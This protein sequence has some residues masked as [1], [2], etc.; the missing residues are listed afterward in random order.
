MNLKV[1]SLVVAT[2]LCATLLCGKTIA[3]EQATSTQQTVKDDSAT[4]ADV[5]EHLD[6]AN[7]LRSQ[8]ELDESFSKLLSALSLVDRAVAEE[9]Y[10]RAGTRRL[11]YREMERIAIGYRSVGNFDRAELLF[12]LIL[13]RLLK[14]NKA[15]SLEGL[16]AWDNLASVHRLQGNMDL[17]GE[18]YARV[19]SRAIQHRIDQTKLNS[20]HLS[21][22]RSAAY[23]LMRVAE[24]A[25]LAHNSEAHQW[26]A[27]SVAYLSMETSSRGMSALR[28]A[29]STQ[30]KVWKNLGAY[31]DLLNALSGELAILDDPTVNPKPVTLRRCRGLDRRNEI[32]ANIAVLQAKLGRQ[33]ESERELR[34]LL[35]IA[36][37]SGAMASEG[38]IR[39]RND[40]L[41]LLA[42]EGRLA[43][44]DSLLQQQL[45]DSQK[46]MAQSAGLSEDLVREAFSCMPGMADVAW[47]LGVQ[48]A[49]GQTLAAREA[50]SLKGAAGDIVMD[51][52]RAHFRARTQ[53]EL[54]KRV[55]QLAQIATARSQAGGV[56][57]QLPHSP[58]A[59]QLFLEYEVNTGL[60][61]IAYVQAG[62]SPDAQDRAL[63]ESEQKDFDR[64]W[65]AF[66]AQRKKFDDDFKSG[67]WKTKPFDPTA[68]RSPEEAELDRAFA[69]TLHPGATE[70]DQV[71]KILGKRVLVVFR[72]FRNLATD[73]DE[74]ATAVIDR[75]SVNVMGLGKWR[76][77]RTKLTEFRRA[78]VEM[79]APRTEQTAGEL[80]D[81]LW[82]PVKSLLPDGAE[83]LIIPDSDLNLLPFAALHDTRSNKYL[84]ETNW[85][86]MVASGRDLLRAPMTEAFSRPAVV[87]SP[88]FMVA[89][90]EDESQQLTRKFTPQP[91]FATEGKLV[92]AALGPHAPI[93]L[94]GA[95][96]TESAVKALASPLYL[97]FSTHAY[98]DIG[99]TELDSMFETPRPEL[100]GLDALASSG[101]ALTGA[102]V[103]GASL[104]RFNDGLLTSLEVSALDLAGTRLVVLSACESGVGPP[105]LG[106]GLASLHRA[107]L[108]AG[109][110]YVIYSL[111]KVDDYAAASLMA[112]FYRGF[113][114]AG[115]GAASP[116]TALRGAQIEAIRGEGKSS[117]IWHWAAFTIA[118]AT[119]R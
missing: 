4:F 38:A 48:S 68:P 10:T 105:Q 84:I 15:D 115:D 63:S 43:A 46:L 16:M 56:R 74:L 106:D 55:D 102:N 47:T 83:V 108:T 39:I 95:V 80:Y 11:I 50:L 100:G 91:N 21:A 32:L 12:A 75:Y 116:A 59:Q 45:T 62:R 42:Q 98:V 26:A 40:L 110:R 87:F 101:L 73:Q 2:A 27:T 79:Q 31:D 53:P 36:V 24:Q 99:E 81:L 41:L 33:T 107:F 49:E 30:R 52:R 96:A 29:E 76:P 9:G 51:T 18:E 6:A 58:P 86:Q 71:Q 69:K 23:N 1:S 64:L 104:D 114:T 94:S 88:A 112:G 85:I 119:S 28:L 118:S 109:A 93:P 97:H 44:G 8:G 66:L 54:K 65:K 20:I 67:K 77:V 37:G 89:D 13:D 3:Q 111:W 5:Y 103:G 35:E 78:I 7:S 14:S 57:G 82:R 60:R 113:D 22:F 61:F 117:A 92:M 25:S 19:V 34:R 70:L 90:D 72:V 17:A